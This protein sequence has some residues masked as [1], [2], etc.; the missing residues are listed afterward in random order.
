[1]S[2]KPSP[3]L[4]SVAALLLLAL[5]GCSS[6]PAAGAKDC[7]SAGDCSADQLCTDGKCA[8]KPSGGKDADSEGVPGADA[9]L[10]KDA[11]ANIRDPNNPN[12]DTDC[13]GL[14]D[15]EE[16]ANVYTGGKK[17][18][19]ENPDTDGDG[20]PDGVELGRLSSPDKLCTN[21]KPDVD[22][23]SKTSPVTAD[24]DGDGL[25][26]GQEDKNH[27][28]KVDPGETNPNGTDSDG[29][30][31]PDGLEDLNQNGVVDPGETDPSNR[32]TDGDKIPDGIEDKNKNGKSD[33]GETDATKRDTDGDG[34]LD[35]DEDRNWNHVVDLGETDPLKAGDC[36]ATT[37]RDT[38][39]D[40]LADKDEDKN[41]NT[42]IDV[43][44]TDPRT[45]DSDRDGLPDGLELG[46]TQN[47]DSASCPNAGFTPDLDSGSRTNPLLIDTDCDGIKD[48]DEDKNHN[49]RVDT[50]ETDPAKRDTD[51]DGIPDGLEL[52]VCTNLDTVN[53]KAFVADADC[54]ATTTDPL[55]PDSD[56][57]GIPD[58]A[59]DSNQNGKV[60]PGELNPR[61][62]TDGT[63]PAQQAC[64]TANLRKV[65]FNE[66]VAPDLQIAAGLEY[67]EILRPK[68]NGVE[69]AVL[70]YDP[71]NRVVGLA[72]SVTP[73]G[74]LAS[75]DEATGRARRGSVGTIS[76]NVAQNFTTWDK[77]NAS[78]GLY[79][80]AGGAD[81]KT[82]ANDILK[83]YLGAGTT[84]LFTGLAGIGGPFKVQA[85]FVRR[86]ASRTVVVIAL[87][88]A[89]TFSASKP[90]RISDIGGGSA[91]AQ[92]GDANAAQCE[93]FL[94]KP[95]AKVDFLW[96]VDNS[97]SMAGYQQAVA[98]AG[99]TMV[100]KLSNS[101]VDWRMAATTTTYYNSTSGANGFRPFTTDVNTIKGW[102]A[103]NGNGWFGISGDPIE[104]LL[105]S[106]Q[107]VIQ[108]QLLPASAT[109]NAS[110]LR[111]GSTLAVLLMG[112]ADDQ[113]AGSIA[114]YLSFY[115][116][117]DGAGGVAQVHG[118]LCPANDTCGEDQNT[119]RKAIGVVNGMNGVLGDINSAN[120]GGGT[121]GPTID[122]ILNSAIAGASPYTTQKPPIASTIKL[123]MDPAALAD[124]TKC[125]A[126]DVPRDRT[127]GFDFDSVSQRILFFGD[128][129]PTV[130]G[131]KVALSYRYWIDLTSNP[132]GN[133]DPCGVC[134][135]PFTC[136]RVTAKCICPTDCG[137]PKPGPG[138][139]CQPTSCK[140]GCA[141]DCDGTCG[142]TQTC[143]VSTCKCECNQNV[144]CGAGFKFNATACACLCDTAALN[145]GATYDADPSIC[146]CVCK[147]T[148]NACGGCPAGK[149]CDTSSCSCLGGPG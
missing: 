110:K 86:S 23:T 72:L 117:Y 81:L 47:P 21:Y 62:G 103:Q 127:S 144:T 82:R 80:Y 131:L 75:D 79:D 126:A 51:G 63:G 4:S 6:D 91:L 84:D 69:K 104:E 98:N 147:T 59:E 97:G 24:S 46:V 121:L 92:F 128:C 37:S 146:A 116:N 2:F 61:D 125:N 55:N 133:P 36:G 15:A 120:G 17:T 34:C 42:V 60:D 113:S 13:D 38:D 52:G 74:Q 138:Y 29:D 25:S 134:Q 77:F 26:D 53:C 88:P 118:I 129:R 54:G 143:N 56:G 136:D 102:F 71:T 7:T 122:A 64:S 114:T 73:A 32:D 132:D 28:G 141:P 14:S 142:G 12:K 66:S 95:S 135:A 19:P 124:P 139:V 111:S 130:V 123:A 3:H 87:Q 31:L 49:G 76:N 22:P 105:A 68:V 115:K 119:P 96:V 112:D 1:M 40:G 145:C 99:N 5:S 94:T 83:A 78:S 100:S 48:G 90:F 108:N 8:A 41:G 9:G 18:D 89:S 11:S 106:G 67:T 50:G 20:V 39:C 33:P 65:S 137:V 27:N 43:G 58:G 148:P 30:G 85:E 70:L 109:V 44:E 107:K 35:G 140:W 16:F 93:I 45:R 57:D 10:A 101:A 149:K